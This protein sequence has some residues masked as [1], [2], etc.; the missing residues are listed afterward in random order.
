MSSTVNLLLRQDAPMSGIKKER[1]TEAQVVALPAGEHD[2]FDRKSGAMLENSGFREKCAKALSAF[3][4][5]GGGHLVL[6]VCDDGTFD[7]VAPLRGRTPTREWIEQLIPA[8]LS[9]PLEDFRVHEV[10][11]ATPSAIPSGRVAIVID[12]GDSALAPHQAVPKKC[13]YYREGGHSTPAPHF[14]LETLR[15]R[16]VRPSLEA[17]LTEMKVTGVDEFDGGLFVRMILTFRIAN[18]GRVAAYK[19]ALC[20][21]QM[22]G[23]CDGREDD[24]KFAL[25][26]FPM[27]RGGIDGI[28]IDDTIL[29]SL[30]LTERRHF[31]LQ[32]RPASLSKECLIAELRAMLPTDFELKFRVVSETSP[33]ELR[34]KILVDL[35]DYDEIVKV[36]VSDRPKSP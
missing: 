13:Y 16:L 2:Y 7:G 27:K 18:R 8:L 15:N 4:N 34:S 11:P 6:G 36:L 21:D 26:D 14:Y 22:F 28:R 12:I 5:S 32:L 35:I 9:Y 23:H 1:W 17:E 30:T 31:G 19:W 3:A 20:I 25:S 10:E 24:Y 29:P 33:G